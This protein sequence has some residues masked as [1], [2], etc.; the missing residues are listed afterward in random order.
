MPFGGNKVNIGAVFIGNSPQ[1]FYPQQIKV[2]EDICQ[3]QQ[4]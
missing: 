4:V 3:L 2:N 1:N